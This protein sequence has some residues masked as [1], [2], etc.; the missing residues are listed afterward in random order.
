MDMKD[1]ALLLISFAAGYYLVVHYGKT[2]AA[3]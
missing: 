3:A 1:I 2:G